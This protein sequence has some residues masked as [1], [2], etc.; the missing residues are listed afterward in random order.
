MP[1]AC[2]LDPG[3]VSLGVLSK[4]FGLAGLRVG[5]VACRDREVI[6]AMAPMKLKGASK[7]EAE[8]T[9]VDLLTKVGILEK[10]DV[11]PAKLSGGQQQRVAIA[12]ALAMLLTVAGFLPISSANFGYGTASTA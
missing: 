9:A 7:A 10:A 3:A 8:K 11:F 2:D 6:E 12:R 4:S 5:W 1:A